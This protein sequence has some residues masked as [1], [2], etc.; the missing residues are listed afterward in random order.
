MILDFCLLIKRALQPPPRLDT[1]AHDGVLGNGQYLFKNQ[2]G[3]Q[4]LLKKMAEQ[5]K[6]ESEL[7][8]QRTDLSSGSLRR[9]STYKKM[10]TGLGGLF[11]NTL[12]SKETMKKQESTQSKESAPESRPVESRGKKR[13]TALKPKPTK[14][15]SLLMNLDL[16]NDAQA[17]II[18]FYEPVALQGDPYANIA[19][20]AEEA[21][22]DKLR[23]RKEDEEKIRRRKEA[24]M[25]QRRQRAFGGQQGAVDEA[26]RASDGRDTAYVEMA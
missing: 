8:K 11:R 3:N 9:K 10:A 7:K 2:V 23:Q 22:I 13:K 12:K 21:T 5:K 1:Y 25:R 16:D 24:L 4:E 6:Q 14:G 19:P 20:E 18:P 26:G 17:R 15:E